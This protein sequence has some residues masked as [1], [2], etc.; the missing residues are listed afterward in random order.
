[1]GVYFKGYEIES[2]NINRS[3]DIG[4]VVKYDDTEYLAIKNVPS[5]I[6]ISMSEYWKV[7]DVESR[8][9]NVEEAVDELD[10][11]VEGINLNDLTDVDTTGAENGDVLGYDSSEDM[12]VPI[13]ISEGHYSDVEKR[14][15]TYFNEALYEKTF[16]FEG[17]AG[18]SERTFIDLSDLTT[19]NIKSVISIDG[20]WTDGN[21]RKPFSW[22][23]TSQYT[24]I[25]YN[26]TTKYLQLL[27]YGFPSTTF[28]DISVTIRYTKNNA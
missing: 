7:E 12:F 2:W 15:G 10:E 1:M 20:T 24:D 16:T 5:G 27:S 13:S 9:S 25:V 17:V 3:Y 28:E 11:F 6:N 19:L 22:V 8:L 18:T 14:I 26:Y 4:S 23:S 21:L